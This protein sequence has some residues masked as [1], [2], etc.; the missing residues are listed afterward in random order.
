MSAQH[1]AVPTAGTLDDEMRPMVW[2]ATLEGEWPEEAQV[3][4]DPL[5]ARAVGGAAHEDDARK[6]LKHAL[7]DVDPDYKAP[8]PRLHM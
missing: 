7:G 6:E 3:E 5:I 8:A 4:Q 2:S 1:D